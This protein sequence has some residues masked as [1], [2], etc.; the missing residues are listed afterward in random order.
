MQAKG[1]LARCYHG[2]F[3]QCYVSL[4]S[5]LERRK[6]AGVRRGS[7]L[8]E[9]GRREFF[10]FLEKKPKVSASSLNVKCIEKSPFTSALLL[11]HMAVLSH[12][13]GLSVRLS[14]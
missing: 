1:G 13:S 7:T 4:G 6:A 5:V 3:G 9:G 8:K 11:L 12:T 14:R 10:A 2:M